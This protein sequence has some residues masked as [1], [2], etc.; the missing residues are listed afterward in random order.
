MKLYFR[1]FK[2]TEIYSVEIKF[3]FQ[4]FLTYV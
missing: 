2:I 3:Q 4:I 1:K